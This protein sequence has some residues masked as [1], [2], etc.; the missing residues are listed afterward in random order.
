LIRRK[1]K[2]ENGQTKTYILQSYI[3][4]PFLYNNRKFDIR[5]Y[6]ML[7]SVNGILKAYWYKEGY[8]R[9]SS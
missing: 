4:K 7:T 2:H 9:T 6:M 8:I 1:E 3:E 5:H